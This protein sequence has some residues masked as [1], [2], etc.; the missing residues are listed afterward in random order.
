M[1]KVLAAVV[2]IGLV[3]LAIFTLKAN[4][5][6]ADA[7][8]SKSRVN[9]AV[10]VSIVPVDRQKIQQNLAI[11]GTVMANNDVM[12]TSETQG[13]IKQIF[14]EVG[15]YKQAGA[16]LAQVDD[17]LKRASLVTAE[18]NLQKAQ[19]DV[20]RYEQLY[21]DKAISEQQIETARLAV[22]A[23]EAQ[24][25]TAQRLLRDTRITA[26]ISGVVTARPA[27]L[28][29]T[30]QNGTPIVNIVDISRLKVKVNLPENDVFRLHVGD[31]VDVSTDIYPS[32]TFEGRVQSVGVKSDEAHTY[33][34]EITLVNNGAHPL[35]AG[36]FA[37]VAFSS[38]PQTD[39]LMIP[40]AAILG[41]V[42]EAQVYVVQNGVAHLRSIVVGAEA[43]TRIQVLSGLSQGE[44]V[45]IDGQNNLT[46]NAPVAIVK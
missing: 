45:V 25:T 19:D 7:K 30:I 2:M 39:A 38:I 37:R 28:G 46:D 42:K 1:K 9:I 6:K 24:V 3:A 8:A 16:V 22:R 41:S 44:T 17:E 11:V 21:Q 31:R 14:V 26:P 5:A 4:K 32:V 10:P 40:R 33:P 34:V 29:A 18:V 15:D 43:G 36:M 35:K 23:A 20:K 27:S 12:V 13:R